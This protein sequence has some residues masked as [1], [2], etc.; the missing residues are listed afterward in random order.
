MRCIKWLFFLYVVN[1]IFVLTISLNLLIG[2]AFLPM[3]EHYKEQRA[4][5]KLLMAKQI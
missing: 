4:Y 2:A 1:H 5:N 3:H